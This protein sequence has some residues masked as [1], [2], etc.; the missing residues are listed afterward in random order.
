[1][2]FYIFLF[3]IIIFNSI[4]CQVGI[5]TSNPNS[6]A[7]LDITS[8]NKGLLLPRLS[9]VSTTSFQPLLA[10]V[11]GIMVYNVATINDVKPGYYINDGTK[12]Q[13]VT[14]AINTVN[15]LSPTNLLN[16]I[17][18]KRAI[19]IAGQSNTHYGA[20]DAIIPDFSGK[21]L[22]Q[23]GRSSENFQTLPL[24][25]Y[26]TYHHSRNQNAGSFGS[27]FL[28]HYYNKLQQDFPNR[29]IQLLL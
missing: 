26:G 17:P 28:Y 27:I 23:L 16:Q 13:S 6:S 2:K 29:E 3:T 8:S 11:A 18:I 5:G 22:A 19:F 15:S 14:D 12:W 21:N 9:L 20:G 10:H 24:T 4:Y 1:M 7:I 25:F